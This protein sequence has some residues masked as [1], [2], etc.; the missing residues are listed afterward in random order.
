MVKNSSRAERFSWRTVSS[1]TL[2]EVLV[3]MVSHKPNIQ[4][5]GF[6][7]RVCLKIGKAVRVRV[8]DFFCY[9]KHGVFS[10]PCILRS[11]MVQ[12]S[13]QTIKVLFQHGWQLFDFWSLAGFPR[14][15]SW[16]F[17]M[18]SSWMD[19]HDQ[20][21]STSWNVRMAMGFNGFQQG[22]TFVG[23]VERIISVIFY[24]E[25]ISM[26]RCSRPWSAM[27]N[28]YLKCKCCINFHNNA[29]CNCKYETH[30]FFPVGVHLMMFETA[31]TP[32]II[33]NELLAY[34]MKCFSLGMWPNLDW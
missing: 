2:H 8:C 14:C 33:L 21:C 31:S 26:F 17:V 24:Q 16:Y 9:R 34:N 7:M 13:Y 18:T 5:Y 4:S 28:V 11:Q 19:K 6:N 27:F 20:F 10:Q 25:I 29:W 15:L 1:L 30:K 12:T 3:P 22:S 32:D 23:W